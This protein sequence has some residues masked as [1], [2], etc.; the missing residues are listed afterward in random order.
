MRSFRMGAAAALILA[1]LALLHVADAAG[2]PFKDAADRT[3]EVPNKI[4]KVIPAGPPAEVLLYALAPDRLAGLVEAF[5]AAG[6]AFVPEAY[7]GLASIPRLSRNPS[8]EDMDKLR[9]LGADLIVDYGNVGGGF[10]NAINKAQTDVG[11]PAILLDGKLA[12]TPQTLRD[13]GK[14][15]GVPERGELLAGLTQKALDSLAP[16]ARLGEKER[17][18]VYL[19]R[20]SD[21]LNAARAGTTLSEAIEF[22][23]GR[24]VTI[25]GSGAFLKL[26]VD[27]AVA[28]AP[29]VVIFEDPAALKSPLRAALPANTR[30][31]LD[32][33]TPFGA[34]ESPPSL[35]RIIGAV[36]L[37]A[38]LHPDRA[39]PSGLVF[40]LQQAFF[41]TIPAGQT[42]APLVK[43]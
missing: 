4:S 14:L 28:L 16:L 35:N 30:V 6:K 41:G 8:P 7:R 22:A 26:S 38:V 9:Q 25:A 2:A 23:G 36:S 5:P 32:Q 21:G 37:A 43:E 40:E 11:V 12:K 15:I 24:N 19:A 20:G 18:A 10:V 34:L 13:L 31:Y 29:D 27:E 33:P 42:F 3:V 39:P 1:F 17:V